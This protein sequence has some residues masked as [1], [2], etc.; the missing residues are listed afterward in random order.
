MTIG[1][2]GTAQLKTNTGHWRQAGFS[3]VFLP[4]GHH[5]KL[6]IEF[7][8]AAIDLV[9]INIY[10]YLGQMINQKEIAI[11]EKR[12]VFDIKE[13]PQGVYTLNIYCKNILIK[14]EKIIIE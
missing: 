5:D 6:N 12:I 9:K 8:S 3:Q 10:N 4:V 2:Q 14:N 7:N 1:F 13:M 11:N